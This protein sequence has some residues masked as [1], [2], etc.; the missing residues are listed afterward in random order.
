MSNLKFKAD[1]YNDSNKLISSKDISN[2]LH[3]YNI[4]NIK[5]NSLEIYQRAFVHK[6]YINMKDYSDFSKP[7]NCLK[8]FNNSYETLEF[9]GDSI[10]GNIVSLYLYNRYYITHLQDEGFLTKLKIRLVNGEQLST[11]AL[12]MGLDKYIVI[13]KYIEEQCQGRTN[14]NILEDVFESF[15][16]ALYLDTQSYD[17]VSELIINI[18]ETHIDFTDLILN[19]N[20]YKDQILRYLQHK[21]SI[22]PEYITIKNEENN[23]FESTIYKGNPSDKTKIVSSVG[24]TKKKAEQEVAKYALIYYGLL[25]K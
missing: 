13:S 5:I 16:G 23:I 19:D 15:I 3:K 25:N 8:L 20:N 11:F 6:S 10:I 17:L 4:T 12:N 9:L 2:I 7:K 18:I 21:F 1:P 14:T 22:Y 24:G